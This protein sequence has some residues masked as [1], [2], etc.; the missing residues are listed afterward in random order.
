MCHKNLLLL[1]VIC[2]QM[3]FSLLSFCLALYIYP[4]EAQHVS[5]FEKLL[6]NLGVEI[7]LGISELD[8]K[9]GFKHNPVSD[10]PVKAQHTTPCVNKSQ[11][12]GGGIL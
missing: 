9:T 7:K 4:A 12:L 6:I 10:E 3:C 5:V 1:D 2:R 8:Q 11:P